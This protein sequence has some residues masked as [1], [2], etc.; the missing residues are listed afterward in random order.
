MGIHVYVIPAKRIIIKCFLEQQK[1][2]FS[3]KKTNQNLWA[4]VPLKDIEKTNVHR[5]M[6]KGKALNLR[7]VEYSEKWEKW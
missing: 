7:K 6:N 1:H 2:T 5:N 4:D 3:F